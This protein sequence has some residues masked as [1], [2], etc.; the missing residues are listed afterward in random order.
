MDA[1]SSLSEN[2]SN[3]F[4]EISLYFLSHVIFKYL[5]GSPLFILD[6]FLKYWRVMSSFMFMGQMLQS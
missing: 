1:I 2:I 5:F 4:H 3:N 6:A